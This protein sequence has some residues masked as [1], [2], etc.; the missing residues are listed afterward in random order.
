L[1]YCK[2]LEQYNIPLDESLVLKG[3]QDYESNYLAIK[4]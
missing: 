4:K 3:T 1:G 2:A